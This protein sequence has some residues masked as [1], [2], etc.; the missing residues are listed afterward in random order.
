MSHVSCSLLLLGMGEIPESYTVR[1]PDQDRVPG[2]KCTARVETAQRAV[3]RAAVPYKNDTERIF[4]VQNA[5]CKGAY[6]PRRAWTEADD[7]LDDDEPR[8]SHLTERSDC[9]PL[10]NT[11]D[12][13]DS[14]VEVFGVCVQRVSEPAH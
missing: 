1:Y 14:L 4:A 8:N 10:R 9:S 5:T 12:S 6:T 13:L 7:D 2:K 11:A 3:K